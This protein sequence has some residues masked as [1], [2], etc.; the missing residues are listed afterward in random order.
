MMK[1]VHDW[2]FDPPIEGGNTRAKQLDDLLSAVRAG[3]LG[4]RATLWLAGAVAALLAAYAQIK[5]L[6]K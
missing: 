6:W 5:G 1:R 4:G 3:K 2:L